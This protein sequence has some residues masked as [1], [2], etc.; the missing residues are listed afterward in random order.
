MVSEFYGR[1]GITTWQG[2]VNLMVCPRIRA[3]STVEDAARVGPRAGSQ[4][5]KG[6]PVLAGLN[7]T[8]VQRIIGTEEN[9]A[10]PHG[11]YVHVDC[12]HLVHSKKNHIY[13]KFK[14]IIV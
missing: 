4:N 12:G 5:Y 1:Q 7:F 6:L 9:V 8:K 11:A 2:S 13:S 14:I 10:Y 3:S